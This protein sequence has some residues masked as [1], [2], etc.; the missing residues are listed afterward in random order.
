MLEQPHWLPRADGGTSQRLIRNIKICD[1]SAFRRT[2]PRAYR[3]RTYRRVAEEGGIAASFKMPRL[4]R[5][6]LDRNAP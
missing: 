2:T 5:L 4:E 1:W 3:Q 6:G